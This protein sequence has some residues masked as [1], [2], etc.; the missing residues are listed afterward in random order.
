M[1]VKDRTRSGTSA[2]SA[3]IWSLARFIDT[4][5]VASLVTC[6]VMVCIS[7][8]CVPF[9]LA[10]C[11]LYWRHCLK[12]L[13]LRVL[14]QILA[15]LTT[16]STLFTPNTD[17][18]DD[19][20]TAPLEFSVQTAVKWTSLCA[21]RFSAA[22]PFCDGSHALDPEVGRDEYAEQHGIDL[23]ELDRK[24]LEEWRK[25]CEAEC[26]YHHHGEED[27]EDSSQDKGNPSQDQ[28][29]ASVEVAKNK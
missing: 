18:C 9:A 27:D 13:L 3:S 21:C 28:G 24:E 10:R 6:S 23:E 26:P 17:T 16:H 12:T 25:K 2:R 1:R 8:N 20:D 14:V 22:I 15:L 11:S 5:L 19:T 29:E 4:A 7:H